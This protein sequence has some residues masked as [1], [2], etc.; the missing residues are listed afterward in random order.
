MCVDGHETSAAMAYRFLRSTPGP[1]G[2]VKNHTDKLGPNSYGFYE[3][4]NQYWVWESEDWRVCVGHTFDKFD[5][6]PIRFEV[7]QYIEE[8]EA[9]ALWHEYLSKI[10]K[11][12]E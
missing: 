10:W 4:P 3:S 11:E 12:E 1:Q 7:R 2:H 9:V 8:A 6:E 5:T